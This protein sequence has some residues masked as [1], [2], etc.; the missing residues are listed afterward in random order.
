MAIDESTKQYYA[1]KVIDKRHPDFDLH[2]IK[3]EVEILQQLDHPNI[4]KIAEYLEDCPY[5]KK[6]G[7]IIKTFVIVMEL[8][9]NMEL[10]DYISTKR[11]FTEKM[12]RPLFHQ[13]MN[14]V[15]YCHTNGV[16]HRDLKP[17]NIL[18]DDSFKLKVIDFGFATLFSKTDNAKLK[19]FTGTER[20]MAPEIFRRNYIGPEV[21][22]FACGIILFYMVMKR[23]P[24]EIAQPTDFYYREFY[25]NL[26]RSSIENFWTKHLETM[27]EDMQISDEFKSLVAMMLNPDPKKRLTLPDVKVHP[28]YNQE[29]CEIQEITNE[30][31][32][33]RVLI[34]Q[35]L[36]KEKA[37]KKRAKA[38]TALFIEK[39]Q[40]H[41]IFEKPS[42]N[43]SKSVHSPQLKQKTPKE[44][45]FADNE[46]AKET[47]SVEREINERALN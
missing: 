17:E 33:C 40:N 5:T 15:E 44:A 38:L 46:F 4:I 11:C 3:N 9:R 25:N 31:K 2:L 19:T 29:T 28:W 14:A 21:D 39:K 37:R 34:E 45:S 6:K 16:T 8:A 7:T 27:P 36:L 20:Y 12:A 10:A 13:L 30:L 32:E 24:F 42:Y 26:P 22:L 35:A 41:F 1:L 43:P 23:S 18:F 47:G